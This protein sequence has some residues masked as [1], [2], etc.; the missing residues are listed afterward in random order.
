MVDSEVLTDFKGIKLMS[1]IQSLLE[2]HAL[3]ITKLKANLGETYLQLI[4]ETPE[5]FDDI[6]LLR[7][8]LSNL[9]DISICE[10]NIRA[11]IKW[12]L[13]NADILKSVRKTGKPPSDEIIGPYAVMDVHK[14]LKD[15]SPLFII[16]S[17]LANISELFLKVTNEQL[18]DWLLFQRERVFSIWYL[19]CKIE[20]KL[21]FS[22]DLESRRM[23]KIIKVVTINDFSFAKFGTVISDRRFLATL[24]NVSKLSEIYYPQLLGQ[25]IFLNIRM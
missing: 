11:T 13:D 4:D 5:E 2:E 22:S 14:S 23:H 24:G 21:D 3:Q 17:G 16:R 19:F 25:S 18:H 8:I 7:F 15:G 10:S 9:N 6:F 1:G 12:R 20:Y